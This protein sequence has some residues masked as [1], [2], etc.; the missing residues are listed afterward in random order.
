MAARWIPLLLAAVL[1]ASALAACGGDDDSTTPAAAAK[2]A[3]VPTTAPAVVARANANC[4]QMLRQVKAVAR[5][6]LR[7]SYANTLEMVTE[8]LAKPGLHLV[9]RVA[10][11]QQALE[12]IADNPG[13]NRYA[14]LFDPIIVLAEQR[15]RAGQELD[16]PTA[17]RLQVSLT[18]LGEEQR[19]A[20]RSAGLDDCGVDF[21]AAMVRIVER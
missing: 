8:G 19:R 9:K 5:R 3:L 2:R 7:H 17:E 15:V 13:F 21:F 20:A 4:R 10:E 14:D 12:R 11:R 6:S 18:A 1:S 16:V